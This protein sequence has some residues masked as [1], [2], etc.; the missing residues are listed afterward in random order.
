[1]SPLKCEFSMAIQVWEMAMLVS[2]RAQR[3][4]GDK[5]DYKK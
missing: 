2:V 5:S 1:M 4:A 3:I